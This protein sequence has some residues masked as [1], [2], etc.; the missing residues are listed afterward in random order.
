MASFYRWQVQEGHRRDNPAEQVPRA[1]R[2]KPDPPRLRQ[3]EVMAL[4]TACETARERRVIYLGVFAGVRNQELRRLQGRHFER[5]GLIWISPD[6]GKGRRPRWL[7]VVTEL[8]D[9][10]QETST[11]VGHHEYVVPAQRR[12]PIRASGTTFPITALRAK[13]YGG[14]SPE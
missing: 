1:R 14:W 6:V 9:V 5:H 3:E 10:V 11:N 8:A 7:P 12:D 4:L 13:R 2:R